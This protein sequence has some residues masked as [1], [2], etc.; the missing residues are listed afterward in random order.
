VVAV[1]DGVENQFDPS[2]DAQLVENP[3]KIFL[4]GGF[5]ERQ[6]A[7]DISVR[8][9]FG[10]QR[11]DP[12]LAR[13]QECATLHVHDPKRRHLGDQIDKVIDLFC[14]SPDLAA[15]DYRERYRAETVYVANGADLRERHQASRTREW[16]ID[17]GNYIL[18]LGRF[19]PE[20]NCHLLIDAFDAPPGE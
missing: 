14:G 15:M 1:V 20:K 7:S 11:D 17:P 18:Y 4:Y 19:S 8:Q 16:E 9:T 3:E 6:F 13:G 12:F 10:D 5:A 2:G